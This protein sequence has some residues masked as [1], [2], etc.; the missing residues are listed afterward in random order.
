MTEVRGVCRFI[1]SNEAGMPA[2]SDAATL[3]IGSSGAH[4]TA[5]KVLGV[6]GE[7]DSACALETSAIVSAL[8]K[9]SINAPTLLIPITD[10]FYDECFVE[11]SGNMLRELRQ[12]LQPIKIQLPYCAVSPVHFYNKHVEE[13]AVWQEF[14]RQE[15]AFTYFDSL[16]PAHR[17]DVKIF[18]Y[19]LFASGRRK[20]LVAG[21]DK[22]YEK[23]LSAPPKHRHVYEIIRDG[24][25]CRLYF[26][27]EFNRAANPGVDGDMLTN[28]WIRLV[29]WKVHSMFGFCPGPEHVIVLDS[30]TAD[31]F[32]KHVTVQILS[33]THFSGQGFFGLK[34]R[35]EVLC[36]NFSV[37]GKVVE[38]LVADMTEDITLGELNV[39]QDQQ[40]HQ[41]Q[42]QGQGQ[43]PG[44]APPIN[45]AGRRPK[46]EFLEFWVRK[47]DGS[48]S[49]CFIDL[50]VYTRNR[51]FRIFLSSK[52]QKNV[53]LKLSMAD[54]R[55]YGG[56]ATSG[57][58]A[59]EGSDTALLQ[60]V[61]R[62]AM[63]KSLLARTFVV[64]YDI[65]CCSDDGDGAGVGA[66]G[67][68]KHQGSEEGREGEREVEK[69][70][71]KADATGTVAATSPSAVMDVDA[72]PAPSAASAAAPGYTFSYLLLDLA[73][74]NLAIAKVNMGFEGTYTA[75]GE[76][77]GARGNTRVAR[78]AASTS[79]S[80]PLP[81]SLGLLSNSTRASRDE[82]KQRELDSSMQQR[83]PSPFPQ[84][85]RYI[86]INH[87]SLGGSKGH[88]N[89]WVVFGQPCAP[90]VSTAAATAA[91]GTLPGLKI[92]YQVAGNKF[93]K[94]VQRQHKSNGI[95]I[96][97]DLVLRTVTQTCWDPD[98]RGFR[99]PAINI[100]GPIKVDPAR[101]AEYRSDFLD[102]LVML[103]I[104]R[105]EIG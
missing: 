67:K 14:P 81:R 65:F 33:G 100:P 41:Q 32:S 25:P 103:E 58:L 28:K 16:S 45:I 104:E 4:A 7:G 48:G 27:L 22:F 38:A 77:A 90:V 3:I 54:K 5:V 92:R 31:K 79:S 10:G 80:H 93:C 42:G 84:L 69:E 76:A 55:R 1:S 72:A 8:D 24:F 71:E 40:Q 47:K 2:G 96:E 70:R 50:G 51:A 11:I 49:A 59:W 88:V 17:V 78:L 43:G 15:M 9:L 26:D 12:R 19:E 66:G 102:R 35:E 52:Y 61:T 18:S 46:A 13:P 95:Q 23:Y 57:G 99:S 63:Q 94:N 86:E 82:W 53:E 34:G 20:F 89:S 39:Q 75:M 44:A 74:V 29:T 98:C 101:V 60:P 87:A 83:Q 73:H 62:I 68:R 85:D 91:L 30:S 36:A 105:G 56:F 64:P 6:M 37:V 21:M 97:V